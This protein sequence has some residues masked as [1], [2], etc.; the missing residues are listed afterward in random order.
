MSSIALTPRARRA[1]AVTLSA[2]VVAEVGQLS[3]QTDPERF[4]A[5]SEAAVALAAEI[6]VES[7]LLEHDLE[8]YRGLAR[9]RSFALSR[10]ASAYAA[11]DAAVRSVADDAAESLEL[12][13]QNVELAESERTKLLTRERSLVDG[14]QQRRRRIG[15]LTAHVERLDGRPRRESGVLSGSW[16]MVL[17][18]S[19]HRGIFD[20]S[21]T[22]TLVTGVYRM[23]GGFDGSVEGTLVQRKVFLVR[24]DS[25]LGKSM[26]LEGTLSVD[27]T[28]IRG[29]WLSYELAGGE[30]GAGQWSARKRTTSE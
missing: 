10:L 17:M 4:A 12:A 18:P 19:Q 14:I 16:E 5:S 6:D 29:T 1:L 21:Q 26:E 24:I 13:M 30:G 8:D 23:D 28:R 3:A 25:Q 22:G 15:L 9:A 2:L 7:N 27:G 20:L 11:L